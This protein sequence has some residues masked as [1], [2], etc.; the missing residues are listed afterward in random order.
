MTDEKLYELCRNSAKIVATIYNLT[1]E[2]RDDL[3]SM[4]FLKFKKKPPKSYHPPTFTELV[5]RKCFDEFRK[6]RSQKKHLEAIAKNKMDS[7]EAN[8]PLSLVE[9]EHLANYVMDALPSYY[10]D[11][12]VCYYLGCS[13]QVAADILGISVPVYKSRLY[14]ARQKIKKLLG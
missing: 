10:R 11:V 1:R 8:N 14:N 7:Y 12:I 4:V 5:K 3:H 2:E 9:T 13:G 6:K